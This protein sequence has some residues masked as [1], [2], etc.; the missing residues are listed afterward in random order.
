MNTLVIGNSS[1]P[2]KSFARKI[3]QP[4]TVTTLD[5]NLVG[6]GLDGLRVSLSPMRLLRENGIR[7]TSYRVEV[8]LQFEIKL[9]R[10]STRIVSD[11]LVLFIVVPELGLN[12]F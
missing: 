2:V 10:G 6:L 4:L 3:L 8:P 11:K 5:S 12:D 1:Q 7:D 9:T